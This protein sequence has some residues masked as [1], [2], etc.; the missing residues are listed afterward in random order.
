L[1]ALDEHILGR[2]LTKPNDEVNILGYTEDDLFLI[3]NKKVNGFFVLF[4]L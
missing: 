2:L 1:F 4:T 3:K